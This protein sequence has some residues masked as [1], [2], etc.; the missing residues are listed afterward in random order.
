MSIVF[1]SEWLQNTS[2]ASPK[3]NTDCWLLAPGYWSN[4]ENQ[5]EL[6]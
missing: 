1:L 3:T 2:E 4:K 6:I 5:Y